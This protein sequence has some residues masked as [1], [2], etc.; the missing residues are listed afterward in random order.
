[1]QDFCRR[2]G[3]GHRDALRLTLIVEEL[4]TNTVRHGYRGDCDLPIRIALCA[5][6]T[7]VS[8]CY[9]DA[10]PPYDPLARFAS[11]SSALSAPFEARHVGGLGIVLVGVLAEGAHYAYEGGW[12]RLWLKVRRAA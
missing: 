6:E 12:N 3:I 8:L 5:E 2:H 4:F 10:A 11:A 1:V 7:A 9:E